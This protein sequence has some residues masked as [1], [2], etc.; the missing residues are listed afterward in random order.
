MYEP[1]VVKILQLCL[2]CATKSYTNE[3]YNFSLYINSGVI[4]T[5]LEKL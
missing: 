4:V 1:K 5:T 3:V 2:F